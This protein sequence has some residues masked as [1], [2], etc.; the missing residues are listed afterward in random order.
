MNILPNT[1][2]ACLR[3]QTQYATRNRKNSRLWPGGPRT[4]TVTPAEENA[5]RI[6]TKTENQFA[7]SSLG[8]SKTWKRQQRTEAGSANPRPRQRPGV[9]L[10]SKIA[11]HRDRHGG[12]ALRRPK[13]NRRPGELESGSAAATARP[14]AQNTKARNARRAESRSN[15]RSQELSAQGK[16]FKAGTLRTR[17][18][19]RAGM[20]LER[21]SLRDLNTNSMPGS[22]RANALC[23]KRTASWGGA[24]P[25]PLLTEPKNAE[26]E[27]QSSLRRTKISARHRPKSRQEA[28]LAGRPWRGDWRTSCPNITG[29]GLQPEQKRRRKHSP[30]Q[31]DLKS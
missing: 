7:S 11:R 18:K 9:V 25:R 19:F 6:I 8:C 27:H 24:R 21:T 3:K 29:E 22:K 12:S 1:R 4:I 26:I 28:N 14:Q 20:T 23:R 31:K 16:G 5:T 30:Y 17:E 15:P 10:E 2:Y 13:R